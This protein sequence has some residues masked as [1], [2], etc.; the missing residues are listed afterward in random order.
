MVSRTWC[1]CS[2]GA[3]KSI[4]A[5]DIGFRHIG[6]I[7][8]VWRGKADLVVIT[9]VV[10]SI[11]CH[12]RG[13]FAKPRGL[14]SAGGNPGAWMATGTATPIGATEVTGTA[15]RLAP[16]AIL[17]SL[18]LNKHRMVSEAAA[19][20]DGRERVYVPPIGKGQSQKFWARTGSLATLG[21]WPRGG[22][23][24]WTHMLLF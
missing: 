24:Q 9:A 1:G 7:T 11:N 6:P 14:C 10:K 20:Q 3:L 8:N 4:E 22:Q 19:M 18:N 15:G 12:C 16:R 23:S 17:N 13:Q 2:D 5:G 21:R